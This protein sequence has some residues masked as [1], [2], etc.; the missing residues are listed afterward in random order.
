MPINLNAL[1]LIPSTPYNVSIT[2]T[3]GDK[4]IDSLRSFSATTPPIFNKNLKDYAPSS[5]VITKTYVRTRNAVAGGKIPETTPVKIDSCRAKITATTL[6]ETPPI[7]SKYRWKGG[8]QF[9]P[10][11]IQIQFNLNKKVTNAAITGID[12]KKDK[13]Q[14]ILNILARGKTSDDNGIVTV[15]VSAEEM[16]SKWINAPVTEGKSW[17]KGLRGTKI[18]GDK[19]EKLFEEGVPHLL[20]ITYTIMLYRNA[21]IL[22]ALASSLMY[23][24]ILEK[25]KIHSKFIISSDYNKHQKR[26]VI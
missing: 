6:Q 14:Y 26:N 16:G 18:M 20:I 7:S 9:N 15:R 25:R 4:E 3:I 21:W 10:P 23:K 24:L 12:A 22:T 5:A 2:M 8:G 17:Y 1:G 13:F 11:M 19:F